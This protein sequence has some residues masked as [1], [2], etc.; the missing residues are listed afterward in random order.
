[1]KKRRF[2]STFFAAI[3][4]FAAS[5]VSFNPV[6]NSSFYEDS[7][8]GEK[9]FVG[10]ADSANIKFTPEGNISNTLLVSKKNGSNV[11]KDTVK[12]DSTFKLGTNK[13]YTFMYTAENG[14]SEKVYLCYV[15]KAAIAPSVKVC[16]YDSVSN[17]VCDPMLRVKFSNLSYSNTY[18]N[19]KG[20]TIKIK[21]NLVLTYTDYESTGI[22]IN[23]KTI[24]EI[25]DGVGKDSTL[26]ITKPKRKTVFKLKDKITNYEYT[27]DTFY[28]YLPFMTAQLSVDAEIVPHNVEKRSEDALVFGT[29]ADAKLNVGNYL[30][31]GKLDIDLERNCIDN[32]PSDT[33]DARYTWKIYNDST[34]TLKKH[35]DF[36]YQSVATVNNVPIETYGT[37]YVVLSCNNTVCKDTIFTGFKVRASLLEMPYVFT[38]NGDGI[39]DEFRPTYTSIA[40]YKIWIYNTMG[41]KM[42]ESDDITVGWDGTHKGNDCPIGAYYYVVKATGVDGIEYKL[43]GTINLVRNA[44]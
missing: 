40:E 9:I 22:T 29:L 34:G 30:Y 36:V 4:S 14:K 7:S 1:M 11:L 25:V 16:D 19:S 38:P 42:Y 24:E 21:D 18:V 43:K 35:S 5:A 13:C 6:D 23:D 3:A 41:K 20:D 12:V 17:P 28:S 39:N 27:S 2:V 10:E 31:S 33:I 15:K 26:L 8:L 37:Y 44:D 32:T